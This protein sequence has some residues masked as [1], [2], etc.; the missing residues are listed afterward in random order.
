M[1][2]NKYTINGLSASSTKLSELVDENR[3]LNE[4]VDE[5]DRL[6]KVL[7]SRIERLERR[8]NELEKSKKFRYRKLYDKLRVIYV[9]FDKSLLKFIR[10]FFS[11]Y[12][13]RVL[14][15]FFFRRVCGLIVNRQ[16]VIESSERKLLPVGAVCP[17]KK[18]NRKNENSKPADQE[19]PLVTIV[20]SCAEYDCQLFKETFDSVLQQE[21]NDYECVIVADE[22]CFRALVSDFP[23]DTISDGKKARIFNAGSGSCYS[24]RANIGLH[25]SKGKFLT[26]INSG[27]R[28]PVT[29]LTDYVSEINI[30]PQAILIYGD[31]NFYDGDKYFSPVYK[32]DYSP[33]TLL[34]TNYI[35]EAV[36]FSVGALKET[37][38]FSDGY[39]RRYLYDAILRIAELSGQI[40]HIANITLNRFAVKDRQCT[41]WDHIADSDILKKVIQRRE[42]DADI[43]PVYNGIFSI[44]Y[45]HG[46]DR[47]VSVIIPTK[48]NSEVLEVCLKSIFTKTRYDNYEVLVVDNA[49][50]ESE[51]FALF[52]QYK[53]SYPD[54]FRVFRYEKEFNYSLINNFAV[55]KSQAD[56]V[57]FLNNDTEVISPDWIHDMV[58]FAQR[59]TIGSVGVK[60]LYPNGSIQHA[61]MVIGLEYGG[62]TFVGVDGC[63]SG[64]EHQINVTRNY[65]SVTAACM[66]LRRD[67]FLSVGGFDEQFAVDF[68]D[69]DLCLRVREQGYNNV[70]LPHV[71][72]FHY[73]SLTRGYSYLSAEKHQRYKQELALFYDKWKEYFE[74]D[75]C[76]NRN[77]SKSKGGFVV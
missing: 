5:A 59:E 8:I 67:L 29:A 25:Q 12:G 53:R 36:L 49:S 46:A 24:V 62:N 15:N 65:S 55:E 56:F 19:R 42:L 22:I 40:R 39:K 37:G 17:D 28:M 16:L 11:L 57:L 4:A 70:Y 14:F 61:G 48:D 7:Q 43:K 73:E 72:L 35:G 21:I 50:T 77:L 38:G 41:I 23:N 60:L 18:D 51:T 76:Y 69:T 33:D 74:K 30:Y 34:S 2:K 9:S 20:I 31:E 71:E 75:P 10:F 1:D 44:R 68:N 47:Q 58:S 64:Y 66:M 63:L 52:E 32:P 13:L 3:K 27:D 6:N 54:N 45:Q 26:I